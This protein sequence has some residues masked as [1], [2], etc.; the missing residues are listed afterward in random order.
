MLVTVALKSH[1]MLLDN[2][3]DQIDYCEKY[4]WSN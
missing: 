1:V 4:Q 2:I 3:L